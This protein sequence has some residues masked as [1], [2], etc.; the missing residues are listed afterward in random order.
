MGGG[1]SFWSVEDGQAFE[2]DS[3]LAKVKG[4][5]STLLSGERVILNLLQ[6]IT[7][8]ASTT[9]DLIQRLDDPDI[10]VVDTR[11]TFGLNDPK[12][13]RAMWWGFNHRFRL[14]DGVMIKD[15]HISCRRYSK[16]SR[17]GSKT[18]R[19]YDKN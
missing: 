16:G 8:I 13:C 1:V 5:V 6:H 7:G 11:K 3:V 4:P 2:E 17:N 18:A 15:N 9:Q 14:D 12:I 19:T 10:K